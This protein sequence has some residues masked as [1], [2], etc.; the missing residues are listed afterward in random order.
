MNINIADNLKRLRRE[1]NLTQ[2]EVAERVGVSGQAVSKWETAA[3]LSDLPLL[4]S[5]AAFFGVSLDE[6]VGTKELRSRERR[7]ALMEKAWVLCANNRHEEAVPLLR[8]AVSLFP[9]DW[10][11]LNFRGSISPIRSQETNPA[12]PAKSPPQKTKKSHSA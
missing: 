10:E 11:V 4:I 7:D 12:P 3:G 1:R 8:E 2:E 9:D 6:L 5:L